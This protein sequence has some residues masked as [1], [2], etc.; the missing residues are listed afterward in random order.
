M[1]KRQNLLT[2][3]I[4]EDTANLLRSHSWRKGTAGAYYSTWKQWSS[5]CGQRVADPFCSTV[6]SIADYLTELFKK[7]RSYHTVYIHRSANS[8]FHRP[9]DGVKVGQ[10][11]L[12]CRVLN[13]CFNA[14]PPHLR[15]VVTW[16]R[17]KTWRAGV[18]KPRLLLIYIRPHIEV[19]PCTIVGWLVELMSF[20]LLQ[21]E[22][23]LPLRLKP[24]VSPVRRFWLWLT[25]GDIT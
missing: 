1:T 5:W 15:Y 25:F 7:S 11:D 6:A 12:V 17:S 9:I 3:G 24:K 19:V 18:E 2:G 10:Q 16:D 14:R 20:V 23:Q 13:A 8:A 22:V 21:P 4:S